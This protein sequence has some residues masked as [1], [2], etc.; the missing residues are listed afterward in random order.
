MKIVEQRRKEVFSQEYDAFADSLARN[1]NTDV[2]ESVAMIHD[3]NVTTSE[4]F[5]IYDTYFGSVFR[6]GS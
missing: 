6:E 1:M 4:F 2:W 5:R 3:E